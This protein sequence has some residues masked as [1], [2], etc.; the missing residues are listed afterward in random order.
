MSGPCHACTNIDKRSSCSEEL[1]GAPWQVS[2]Q[3][4]KTAKKAAK[5]SAY[6]QN[7]DN[8]KTRTSLKASRRMVRDVPPVDVPRTTQRGTP[9]PKR[10]SVLLKTISVENVIKK[11]TLKDFAFCQRLKMEVALR[12][13]TKVKHQN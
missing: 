11:A 1:T 12:S 9:C 8:A 4:S 6:K 3:D 10:T 7:K 2:S 13:E 5:A